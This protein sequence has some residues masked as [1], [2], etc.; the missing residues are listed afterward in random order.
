[1]IVLN[2]EIG[3]AKSQGTEYF[4]DGCLTELARLIRLCSVNGGEESHEGTKSV[5]AIQH[6]ASLVR[7]PS[8]RPPLSDGL[9]VIPNDPRQFGILLVSKQGAEDQTLAR[10]AFHG[11]EWLSSL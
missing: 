3:I 1:M 11:R 5:G 6:V 8:S 2:G 10:R 7:E 4:K 9:K